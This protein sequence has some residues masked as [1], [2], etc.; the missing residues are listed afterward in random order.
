MVPLPMPLLDPDRQHHQ[1]VSIRLPQRRRHHLRRRIQKRPALGR[2]DGT[3][4]ELG[5]GGLE[6]VTDAAPRLAARFYRVR[7]LYA[8]SPSLRMA[9][10]SGGA[11][12]FS[13]DA[14]EGAQYVVEY[15]GQLMPPEWHELQTITGTSGL[16]SFTNATM[17]APQRFF[18]LR[19][20]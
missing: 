13:L 18:R 10:G 8:P 20:R 17:A 12:N 5:A 16:I 4:A 11:A 14:V 9:V 6:L 3:E 15:T 7:A 19:V 2:L 1:R